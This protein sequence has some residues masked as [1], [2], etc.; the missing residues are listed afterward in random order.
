MKVKTIL[1][2]KIEPLHF[3]I[4][5]IRTNVKKGVFQRELKTRFFLL[6]GQLT[7]CLMNIYFIGNDEQQFAL[8]LFEDEDKYSVIETNRI[9]ERYYVVNQIV[10]V[11]WGI[12]KS[13]TPFRAK[14][15]LCGN[16]LTKLMHLQINVLWKE[17]VS[18]LVC[19]KQHSLTTPARQILMFFCLVAHQTEET[20]SLL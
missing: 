14:L 11:L 18:Q 1:S 9:Q 7:F 17:V 10:H 20:I 8:V 16:L 5:K 4:R 3:K 13:T 15:I 2:K 19:L 12:G 6:N